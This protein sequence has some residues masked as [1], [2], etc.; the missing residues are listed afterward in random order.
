MS[1]FKDEKHSGLMPGIAR[2]G[3]Q[4][5]QC[6]IIKT[7]PNSYHTLHPQCPSSINISPR[8]SLRVEKE[9]GYRKRERGKDRDRKHPL[10]TSEEERL[11]RALDVASPR[12]SSASA[13]ASTGEA[14]DDDVEERRDGSDDGG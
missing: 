6:H 4:T 5:I 14:G 1:L 2:K 10:S 13:A 7:L 12:S 9:D 11:P 8:R 3:H